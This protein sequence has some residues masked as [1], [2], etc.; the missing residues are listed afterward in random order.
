[1]NST[2]RNRAS[3]PKPTTPISERESQ[4]G[5]WRSQLAIDRHWLYCSYE[6]F[7]KHLNEREAVLRRERENE[8]CRENQ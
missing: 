6:E 7:M 8:R 1:M 2:T 5:K 3:H 4:S